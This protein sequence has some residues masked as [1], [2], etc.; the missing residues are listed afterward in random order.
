LSF[1]YIHDADDERTS[2]KI[3]HC[4]GFDET[5]NE[6]SYSIPLLS[7]SDLKN[8]RMQH[9]QL[10]PFKKFDELKEAIIH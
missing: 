2:S 4:I 8:A 1:I 5:P 10:R 6:T 7:T 3:N 9:I